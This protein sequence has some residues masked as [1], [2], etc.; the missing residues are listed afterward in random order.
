VDM[1][2][3]IVAGR[4]WHGEICNI[5]KSG[6]FYWVQATIVPLKDDRGVPVQFIAIRTDITE[7]KLM[8][9]AL[10]AAEARL[11]HIT[12]AVPGVLYRCQVDPHSGRARYTFISERLKDIRGLEPAHVLGHGE[13]LAQQIVAA[14]RE[15]YRKGLMDAA[16]QRSVWR[17]DYRIQLPDGS[18]RWMREEIRPANELADDGSTVFTG[19]CQDVTQLKEASSRLREITQSLPVAVFRARLS[20]DG[21]RSVPFCSPALEKLCGVSADAVMADAELMTACL[22]PQDGARVLGAFR[23]SARTG[24][25]WVQDFRVV[26]AESG[27]TN[28][29]HGESMP[30]TE[31][32]GSIVWNGYLAD[33]TQSMQVS[34]ELRR[35]KEEAEAASRAKSEFL[36]NMSHEIRTPMNGIIGMTELALDSELSE[37]QREYLTIVKTS[38]ES[39]LRVINDILDFS[40]IEAGKLLIERIP[41]HLG[42]TLSET[43]KALAMRASGKGLELICDMAPEVPMLVHGDPG[44]LRQILINLLGNAIKFTERGEV[45]LKL[46]LQPAQAGVPELLLFTISDTGIGIPAAKLNSIFDAFSQEDGSITRRY[47]GTGLGLTISARLVEALGGR[48]WAKSEPGQGSRFYFTVR[49]ERDLSHVEP[50]EGVAIAGLRVLVADDSEANRMLLSRLLRNLRALPTEVDSGPA[51]L[52]ELGAAQ[53]RGECY[54]LIFLD[55]QMPGLDGF[56]TAKQIA[57]MPAYAATPKLLLSSSG[58]KGEAQRSRQSGFAAYLSKPYTGDELVQVLQR[59]LSTTPVLPAELVTRHLVHDAQTSLSVLLVEDHPVNQQLAVQLLERWG[60]RV[61]V[62]GDGQ[63]ALD[64][65]AVR[66]FDLVLMD[67]MMPVLDGLEATRRFRA[68]EQGPRTPIVAMTAKAMQGDRESCLAAG[69]DDYLSK[70]IEMAEFHRV[71]QRYAP[72]GALPPPGAAT[73][74]IGAGQVV[75]PMVGR[76]DYVQALAEADQDVVAIIAEV[77]HEQWPLDLQKMQIA[78]TGADLEA[79]MHVAHS[80]KS[81]MAMFGALP[82]VELAVRIEALA[83]SGDPGRTPELAELV[84]ALAGEAQGL[85]AAMQQA[86]V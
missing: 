34:E 50:V 58:L 59:V 16:A 15:R 84:A 22:H 72:G 53:A 45:V 83:A 30:R 61:T 85:L 74:Q 3:T 29:V 68:S 80:T 10:Q 4:V 42:R 17:D 60:H 56:S 41:F 20:R 79:L 31:V 9:S 27:Q 49:L 13:A 26:H 75:K 33:I 66:R 54:D 46:E 62:V 35:A 57:A 7:R 77:F 86:G 63:A 1:W 52:E 73:S 18:L 67:M 14:D 47:G 6:R 32:D 71:V 43:F 65:L 36:A 25:L 21:V 19:I 24:Q 38:S 5:S 8:E 70:P 39:L 82:A 69:M 44:R 37:E 81:T 48:I 64:V 11:R 12:N 23:E 78:L 76:F 40:K 2:A 55:A 28:W 51:A